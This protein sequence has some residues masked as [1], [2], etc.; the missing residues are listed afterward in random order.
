MGKGYVDKRC[1]Y[2]SSRDCVRCFCKL[3]SMSAST[4]TQR[5]DE[6][7]QDPNE[8]SGFLGWIEK[9]G[10]KLPDPFWLFVILSGVV[11]VS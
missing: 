6:T 4:T 11:A 2:A 9:V 10:N 7:A 5:K 1:P 3:P 8:S